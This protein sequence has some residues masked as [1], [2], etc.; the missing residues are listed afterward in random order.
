MFLIKLDIVGMYAWWPLY[1]YIDSPQMH[2]INVVFPCNNL[3]LNSTIIL[4][5]PCR[6]LYACG[7]LFQP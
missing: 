6:V 7:E 1:F 2:Y 3:L 5:V 4:H